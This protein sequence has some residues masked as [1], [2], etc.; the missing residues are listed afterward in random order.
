MS[1]SEDVG[2]NSSMNVI[3]YNCQRSSGVMHDLGEWFLHVCRLPAYMR[4]FKSGSGLAYVVVPGNEC[5]CMLIK[6]CMFDYA[7]CLWVKN[8]MCEMYVVPVYCRPSEIINECVE[9]FEKLERCMKGKCMLIGMDANASSGLWH[10][11]AMGR[12]WN[13]MKRGKVLEEWIIRAGVDVLNVPP[14]DFTFSGARGRVISMSFS[15]REG[16]MNVT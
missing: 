8:D 3:Q 5:E 12:A 14:Q 15:S 4:V 1:E 13:S 6:E 10:S 7:V 9:Y 2:V 11:K 16:S